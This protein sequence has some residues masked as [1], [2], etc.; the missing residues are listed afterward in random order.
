M[1]SVKSEIKKRIS[2]KG[3]WRW[4]RFAVILLKFNRRKTQI[5]IVPTLRVGTNFRVL[6]MQSE[7]NS[8]NTLTNDLKTLDEK[9]SL[10]NN[11]PLN[12]TS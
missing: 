7:K 12:F 10:V 2:E 3:L 11:V 4:R 5:K 6:L 1:I 9:S 8:K